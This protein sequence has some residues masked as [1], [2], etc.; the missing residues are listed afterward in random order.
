MAVPMGFEVT[1]NP[2]ASDGTDTESDDNSEFLLPY[3]SYT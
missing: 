2:H 1:E 3:P